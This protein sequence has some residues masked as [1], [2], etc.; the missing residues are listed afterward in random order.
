MA[1]PSSQSPPTRAYISPLSH[2]DETSTAA[3]PA[4]SWWPATTTAPSPHH[5]Q[6]Q[7]QQQQ[8]PPQE[9]EGDGAGRAGPVS[10]GSTRSGRCRSCGACSLLLCAVCAC[11]PGWVD[12]RHPVFP[13][14]LVSQ[15]LV[16]APT[17]SVGIPFFL[18][19][20]QPTSCACSYINRHP[21]LSQPVTPPPPS[22]AT[23]ATRPT[24]SRRLSSSASS[25][26]SAASAGTLRQVC[27]V[28]MDGCVT[29]RTIDR[30]LSTAPHHPH[31]PAISRTIDPPIS[32]RFFPPTP[33]PH[34]A[35]PAPPPW[36]K[37]SPSSINVT[38]SSPSASW[39]T[40][41]GGCRSRWWTRTG[42]VPS[43]CLLRARGSRRCRPWAWG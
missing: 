14:T 7:R 36:K 4:R 16:L 24:G 1:G 27:I 25:T 19:V 26:R 15:P 13:S 6:Q 12:V 29:K 9:E 5:H 8:P 11:A 30:S 23:A 20:S 31:P 22:R 10:F 43:C 3:C 32:N 42:A 37:A 33:H 34:Q 28:P 38:P 35:R 17:T 18:D 2:P 39:S 41:A 40:A 21:F